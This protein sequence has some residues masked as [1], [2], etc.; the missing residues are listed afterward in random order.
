MV[1]AGEPYAR[2]DGAGV[3]A[4][5]P[6][7]RPATL[8]VIKGC[9]DSRSR[10]VSIYLQRVPEL[11][12]VKNRVHLDAAADRAIRLGATQLRLVDERSERFYVMQDVEGNEFCSH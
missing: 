10:L 12:Q 7:T 9:L 4:A 5:R 1:R 6:P 11:K 8:L 2:C 3:G